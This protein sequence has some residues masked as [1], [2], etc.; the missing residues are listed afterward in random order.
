MTEDI[1]ASYK[2][3]QERFGLPHLDKLQNVFQ[4]EIEPECNLDEIRNEISG[5]LFDFTER[6]V[7]PLLWSNHHS[8]IV[9]REMLD[10]DE[11]RKL[12]ELYKEIQ[13]LRWRNNLLSI[14]Q[15]PDGTAQW[16]HDL[17]AFWRRF[18]GV[19]TGLCVKF[20]DGWRTL[21]FKEVKAEYQ[22]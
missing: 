22:G 8:H 14:K 20:S 1:F 21:R 7:E 2:K 15:D 9:E 11:G 13:A 3:I 5:R 12:F 19:T 16:I 6:V 18:E 17:W 4:L 10:A